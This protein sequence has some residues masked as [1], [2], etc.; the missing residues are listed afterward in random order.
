LHRIDYENDTFYMREQLSYVA[1]GVNGAIKRSNKHDERVIVFQVL[2]TTGVPSM[3]RVDISAGVYSPLSFL[4]EP[5]N[6]SQQSFTIDNI[7]LP[8]NGQIGSGWP[9]DRST[10]YVQKPQIDPDDHA[11]FVIPLVHSDLTIQYVVGRLNDDDT[12]TFDVPEMP[13]YEDIERRTSEIRNSV[14]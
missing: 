14:P 12:L 2:Q 1:G 8:P 5:V 10:F 9:G 7:P 3:R 4:S 11:R 6:L 13:S